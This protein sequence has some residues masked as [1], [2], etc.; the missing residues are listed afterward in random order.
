VLIRLSCLLLLTALLPQIL[1]AEEHWIALKSG[2]F[3]VLS[4]VGDRPAREKLMLLEQFRE[5]LRVITGKKEMRL[6]W[7]VRVIIVKNAAEIPSAPKQFTLGRDARMLAIPQAGALSR[8]DLKEL[9]RLMLYENTNRLPPHIEQGIIELVSTV[10]IDGPRITLGAPVPPA[11]RSPGW[12]LMHLVT[13][14]PEYAGRSSVMI[15]NLEQ[16]DDFEAACHNAFEKTAAQI[17]QQADAYLQ[18]GNFGTTFISGRALSMTRDFKPV[19]LQGDEARIAWADLLLATGHVAEATTAYKALKG[20]EASEGLAL[21]ELDDQKDNEAKSALEDAIEAHSMSARAW[22]EL[23]RLKSDS[24]QL[25]QASALNPLWAEPYFQLAEL[26]PAIDKTNL[27]Q[28]A[29]LLKKAAALDPRNIDYWQALAKNDI[30]AKDF[31]E[32]QKAWA[33]A[34]HAAS[35]DEER[36][37]IH[38]VRVQLEEKRFDSDAAERK[39]VADEHEADLQRVKNQSEAAI[40]ASE[41]AARKKMNPNG[42]APPKA[43]AWYEAAESGPS[44]QGTFQ[45]LDCLGQGARLVIQTADGKTVQLLMSDPSQITTGGG[46]DQT[47]VCGPQ[48]NARQVTVHYNA[49]PDAKLRTAGVATAIEFH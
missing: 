45:R 36:E 46:G 15:S 28:R 30:A 31:A 47:L 24:D 14:N 32:A 39:R 2:P 49:K 10:Q 40:H 42:A 5:T 21:M 4:N 26:N 38:Q 22:L 8:D 1:P 17:Q 34:E 9:A 25:K 44:V 6:V 7:P 29:V 48:K 13:V 11:E 35:S 12:A 20:P 37:H 16:S 18:A 43:E 3:E 41:D 23:G 33:G 19:Q 27:E